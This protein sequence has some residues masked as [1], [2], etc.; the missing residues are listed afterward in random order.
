MPCYKTITWNNTP[1]VSIPITAETLNTLTD[2]KFE[3]PKKIT[4]ICKNCNGHINPQ[5]MKCEYCDTQY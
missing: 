1:G 2:V 3:E 4:Y 5:T